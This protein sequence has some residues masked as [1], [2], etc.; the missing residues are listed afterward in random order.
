MPSFNSQRWGE[1]KDSRKPEVCIGE[2]P[3]VSVQGQQLLHK[4]VSL[5]IEIAMDSSWHSKLYRKSSTIDLIT[6]QNSKDI[7]LQ[8]HLLSQHQHPP[9]QARG[10]VPVF[11]AA[12]AHSKPQDTSRTVTCMPKGSLIPSCARTGMHWCYHVPVEQCSDSILSGVSTWWIRMGEL[13]AGQ[14]NIN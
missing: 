12:L 11:M 5:N 10:C 6:Q 4:A 8:A 13:P 9:Q 7:E 14:H 2:P 1:H 3:R